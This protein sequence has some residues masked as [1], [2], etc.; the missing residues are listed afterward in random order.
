MPQVKQLLVAI[1]HRNAN[2]DLRFFEGI[3]AAIGPIANKENKGITKEFIKGREDIS[4]G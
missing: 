2:E 4:N 1:A 3:Q